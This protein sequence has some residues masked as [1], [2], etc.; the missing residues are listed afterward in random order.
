MPGLLAKLS[1]ELGPDTSELQVRCG[2]N[3]GPVTAGVLRG[4]KARFQLFGDTVNTTARMETTGAG[5]KIH[6]SLDTADLLMAAGKGHWLEE[7]KDMVHAKGKGALKTFWLKI[8][9]ASNYA[10]SVTGSG[11]SSGG[12]V[13]ALETEPE[14][15]STNDMAVKE[16]FLA[17]QT[18]SEKY[19]RLID[20]NTEILFRIL[21]TVVARRDASKKMP[22]SEAKLLQLEM[23]T[24]RSSRIVFEEQVDVIAL[25]KYDPEVAARQARPEDIVISDEVHDLLR[26][27]MQEVACSYRENPFH[28]FEHVSHVTM[29][30]VKLLS[31]IVAPDI[32]GAADDDNHKTVHDFTYGIT[33]DPI[34]Q[35]SVVFSAL[36]H[37]VDHSGVPNSQLIKEDSP[38]ASVY[39]KKSIAEQNS[40]DLAWSN[41]ME[42]RFKPLRRVIYAT[43]EEFQRFRQL[44]VNTVMATDIMDRDLSIQRKARWNKAFAEGSENY[45]MPDG[46]A[47]CAVNRKATIVIEHLIQASDVAHTMQHWHIYR[48]WNARLFEEMYIAFK[49]GRGSD[50]TPNWYKGEIG[51]FDFYIIPLAKKLKDCG[52]FGVSSDEYLTYAQQNRKEWENRGAEAV[53]EMVK[54]CEDKHSSLVYL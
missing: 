25:P 41:L 33:S 1:T 39:K 52:V 14:D 32:E 26:D 6:V 17:P 27:Y 13:G 11:T 44:V 48:K 54:M 10:T 36:I 23:E 7:R 12:S 21:K 51:F 34:T 20:W 50:P 45:A 28:N 30:V 47:D 3:S 18:I 29:S 4:E 19:A 24:M 8:N 43:K 9:K 38:L 31:R 53:A 2:L 5:G 35:F 42:E 16:I 37:D 46:D 22:T 40:V 15:T 49:A